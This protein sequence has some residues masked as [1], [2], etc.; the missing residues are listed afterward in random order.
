MCEHADPQV[1]GDMLNNFF[2]RMADVIFEH[3]GTLDKFMGDAILAVF[4]APLEQPDHAARAVSAALAM[5]RELA[6]INRERRGAPI[7]MRLALNSGAALT[8]DI[9]SPKRREFTVLGDVVTTAA[10]IESSIAQ[11]D[12]IVI[13]HHTRELLGDSFAVVSLGKVALKG[14]DREIEVYEVKE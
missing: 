2:A 14:R 7:Q 3:D 10:R 11:P 5:R 13:S 9:G 8:G 6:Q 12:Q 4:G 1:I